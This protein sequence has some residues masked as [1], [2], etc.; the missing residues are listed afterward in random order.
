MKGAR[1]TNLMESD[2]VPALKPW[3]P[4]IYTLLIFQEQ[5]SVNIVVAV[6]WK[7]RDQGQRLT[8]PYELVDLVTKYGAE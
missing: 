3:T 4:S 8:M 6:M 1:N 5:S 7:M 2:V